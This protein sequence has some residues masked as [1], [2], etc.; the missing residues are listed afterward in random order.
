MRRGR[1]D[2]NG[3]GNE[4][5]K[6]QTSFGVGCWDFGLVVADRSSFDLDAFP[7]RLSEQ[8]GKIPTLSNLEI[9]DRDSEFRYGSFLSHKL[10]GKD[11][12]AQFCHGLIDEIVF[13]LLIPQRIQEELTESTAL[14]NTGT[15]NFRVHIHYSY[16]GP[17][18][19]IQLINTTSD[20]PSAAVRV[21]RE[22]LKKT[23]SEMKG[24]LVFSFVGPSPFHADF[25]LCGWEGS[26]ESDR[27]FE[28]SIRQS[29]S[30][31]DITFTCTSEM[32]SNEALKIL[33]KHLS[34]ELGFF[35]DFK[36]A[37][38]RSIVHWNKIQK[39]MFSLTELFGSSNWFRN[40]YLMGSVGRKIA[41]LYIKSTQL[42]IT[43]ILNERYVAETC[44]DMF[45]KEKQVHLEALIKSEIENRP[46]FPTQQVMNLLAVFERRRSK[47]MELIVFLVAAV[48]G[49]AMGSLVV[50]LL[51]AG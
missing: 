14:D 21:V 22:Y 49:G 3:T 28:S 31:A 34:R 4:M 5:T 24:G 17:V 48:S 51:G 40:I 23:I 42:E 12:N 25:K 36:L 11:S 47:S 45:G 44:E 27:H 39:E 46:V 1:S 10:P 16:Y 19:Y 43:Q 29:Q 33:F 8:L 35:Y 20:S 9:H 13:D 50:L 26:D 6:Y 38:S 32:H 18:G 37:D 41:R 15:E 2:K 30:Y 7:D